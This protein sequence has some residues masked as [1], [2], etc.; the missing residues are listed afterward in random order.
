[1]MQQKQYEEKNEEEEELIKPLSESGDIESHPSF[2][3]I[4]KGHHE[5]RQEGYYLVCRSCDL[6]HAI[7][8]GNKYMIVGIREDGM[9]LIKTRKELGFI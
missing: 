5:W 2:K 1:M 4:P 9:P 6:E 7:W 3:F 8:I